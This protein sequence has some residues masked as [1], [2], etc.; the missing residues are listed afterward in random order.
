MA[1]G[2]RMTMVTRQHVAEWLD[3]LKVAWEGKD[4]DRVRTGKQS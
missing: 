2:K 4:P 1:E 3:E